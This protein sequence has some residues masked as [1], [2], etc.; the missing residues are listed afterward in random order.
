MAETTKTTKTTAKTTAKT[1]SPDEIIGRHC[2]IL[3]V[4]KEGHPQER[5]AGQVIGT[6]INHRRGTGARATE[7]AGAHKVLMYRRGQQIEGYAVLGTPEDCDPIEAEGI[8]TE[9]HS[10]TPGWIPRFILV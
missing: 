7:F 2:Q 9:K 3:V 8:Y 5:C 6:P 4:D 10:R 1:P